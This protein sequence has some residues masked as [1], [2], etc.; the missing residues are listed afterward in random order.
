VRPISQTTDIRNQSQVFND[1]LEDTYDKLVMIDQQ[2]QDE[3]D[4]SLKFPETDGCPPRALRLRLVW[5]AAL[6]SRSL[7]SS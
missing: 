5:A 6:P 2:Q 4:R 1:V 3:I 7:R